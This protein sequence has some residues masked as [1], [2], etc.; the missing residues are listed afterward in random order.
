MS[1]FNIMLICKGNFAP[2][3]PNFTTIVELG[4]TGDIHKF[5]L[6]CLILG[7]KNR[8]LVLVRMYVL[9]KRTISQYII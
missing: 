7:L 9:E 2:L 3:G 1:I 5:I 4:L 6:N 8:L